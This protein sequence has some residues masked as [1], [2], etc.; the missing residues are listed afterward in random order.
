[1]YYSKTKSN[2]LNHTWFFLLLL[3]YS[4][5][6]SK[7]IKPYMFFFFC[8]G[9]YLALK[10]FPCHLNRALALQNL[11]YYTRPDFFILS[12]IKVMG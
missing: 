11:S 8:I 6:K 10:C 4:K 12:M 1:M 7:S 2:K 9:I 3:Y 5:T